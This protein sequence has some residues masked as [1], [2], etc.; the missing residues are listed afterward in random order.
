MNIKMIVTDLDNT[1]VRSDGSISD[2]TVSI[3][4]KCR[5]KGIKTAFATARSKNASARYTEAFSPDIFIGYGGALTFSG[6]MIIKR[7]AIPA[8]VSYR[9]INESL[10]EPAVKTM[11]TAP[12][13]GWRKI[14][15]YDYTDS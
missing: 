10:K 1:L 13:N 6:D 8:D 4:E 12:L 7:Y 3:L 9:I 11:T 14:Y 5:A 2:Y 15:Y